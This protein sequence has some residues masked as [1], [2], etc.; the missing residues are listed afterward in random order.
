MTREQ[1]A[2]A[3]LEAMYDHSHN[4]KVKHYLSAIYGIVGGRA[5]R[6]P[7]TEAP[8]EGAGRTCDCGH[9]CD[10][11]ERGPVAPSEPAPSAPPSAP[12]AV[13]PPDLDLD[14]VQFP[15]PPMTMLSDLF[16]APPAVEEP[17]REPNITQPKET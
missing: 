14:A 5:P 4:R 8:A 10:Y 17:R 15:Q 2:V 9:V 13:E 11:W 1:A 16:A 12:P 6:P 7:S 3:L